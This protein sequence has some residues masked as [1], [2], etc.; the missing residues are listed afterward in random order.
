[1][2]YVPPK[3]PSAIPD[4]TDLPDRTDDI[5]YYVADRYNEIKKELLAALNELGSSPKGT[6][7]S[8][9][10]RLNDAG[11]L[12]SLADHIT[13]SPH[14]YSSITQ[15]SWVLG[16]NT[17][18]WTNGYLYN[19][20]A[21]NGDAINF[22]FSCKAGVYTFRSVVNKEPNRAIYQLLVDT[23]SIGTYDGYNATGQNN[24][25]W[26]ITGISL[27]AG[28]HTI[29]LKANGK[30]ASS[31]AYYTILSLLSILRTA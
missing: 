11:Y 10:A 8:V 22:T 12:A 31:S 1:M 25:I 23:V 7:A 3:Y 19:S 18:Q 28:Q 14:A 24:L 17:A 27:T 29:Q 30:N 21:A 15:G 26:D 6:Y 20:S 5:D 2:T 16:T 4:T 9:K 13:I